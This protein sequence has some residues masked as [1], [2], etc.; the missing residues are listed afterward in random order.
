MKAGRQLELGYA[1]LTADERV[2]L[3]VGALARADEHEY[4]LVRASS[5]TQKFLG[6]EWAFER[7]LEDLSGFTTLFAAVEIAPRAARLR[8]LQ[9]LQTAAYVGIAIAA[10]ETTEETADFMALAG[11]AS[12]SA[13]DVDF[14]AR[15][16]QPLSILEGLV[17]AEAAAMAHGFGD[18]CADELGLDAGELLG[19]FARPFVADFEL[20]ASGNPDEEAADAQRELTSRWWQEWRAARR[21]AAARG[22]L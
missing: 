3:A 13:D 22:W 9:N 20:L 10:G 8:L 19:A 18:F 17:R 12:L 2:R 5:P 14:F 11:A 1:S 16:T 6:C 21:E 15:F 4:A 7:S